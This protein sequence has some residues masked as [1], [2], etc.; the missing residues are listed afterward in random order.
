MTTNAVD[1][2]LGGLNEGNDQFKQDADPFVETDKVETKDE[3]EEEVKPIPFAKDPKIQK[4]IDKQIA[5]RLADIEPTD[6]REQVRE[7]A[8]EQT[9]DL[10]T[11]F[12][13]IIGNDTPEKVHALKMLK[14]TVSD[15]EDKASDKAFER[16]NAESYAER[17]AEDEAL[18]EL[19]EG[20]ENIEQTFSVDLSSAKAKTL[21][22]EFIDFVKQVAPKD[23]YGEVTD[24]P[25]FEQTFKVFQDI[26]K[27]NQPPNRAKQLA[28]RS[29]S[30]SSD[31]SSI[32]QK[33][34]NSWRDVDKWL[35][36]LTG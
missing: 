5:K 25:D 12:T 30:N 24:Y 18:S 2:F 9:E 26:R 36:K 28:A 6:T 31:A 3:G 27:A 10:I 15:L 21:R 13:A 22:N 14:K 32:P 29:M 20:F 1:D 8:E 11:A 35:S 4:Y 16:L 23:E 33:T 19:E 34:G 7:E 17:E